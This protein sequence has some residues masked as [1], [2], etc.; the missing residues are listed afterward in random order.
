[1]I[2][3]T[4]TPTVPEDWLIRRADY[5][6][7][8]TVI[9]IF[10]AVAEAAPDAAAVSSVE[11]KGVRVVTYR[12]L[13]DRSARLAARLKREGVGFEQPV[14][15]LSAPSIDM[16]VATLAIVRAG[17]YYVP[18]DPD[19]PAAR[20]KLMVEDTGADLV[21]AQTNLAGKI[22]GTGVRCLDLHE[23]PADAPLEPGNTGEER[24]RSLAYAMYTSGST[25]KPKG[26]GVVHRAISR[27]VI[28]TNYVDFT[29]SDRVA[30]LANIAFDASTLEIWGALLNGACLDIL[31]RRVKNFHGLFRRKQFVKRR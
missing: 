9:S 20:L 17:A 23:Q 8:Q 15:L 31:P 28:N 12:A 4:P 2:E 27:L 30:Q 1:M 10:D 18:L 16:I 19:Y 24:S 29:P 14:G 21:L 11:G 25:G 3:T 7:D 22:D 13:A 5:P 26:V 6:R